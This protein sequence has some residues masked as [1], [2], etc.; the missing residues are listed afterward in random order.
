MEM[1]D[2]N[3]WLVDGRNEVTVRGFF[4]KPI[5]LEVGRFKDKETFEKKLAVGELDLTANAKSL[6]IQLVFQAHV[7]KR[8]VVDELPTDEA[9]RSQARTLLELEIRNQYCPVKEF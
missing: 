3:E 9:Y 4:E 8:L 1:E 7:E 2:I 5:Y 6:P